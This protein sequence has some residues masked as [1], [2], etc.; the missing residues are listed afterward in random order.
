MAKAQS[1]IR[2]IKKETK[3]LRTAVTK[4][5]NYLEDMLSNPDLNIEKLDELAEILSIK[6]ELLILV[7]QQLEFLFKPQKFSSEFQ[8]TEE[9][10]EKALSWQS[11][12]KRKINEFAKPHWCVTLL[13]GTN[14]IAP[15]N[16]AF[17]EF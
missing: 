15:T 14:V 11:R 6:F 1:L 7:Y 8:T 2:I 9:Y 17:F 4:A 10:G 16:R 5:V 13:S 12:G 3:I